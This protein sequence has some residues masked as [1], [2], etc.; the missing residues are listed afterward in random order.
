MYLTPAYIFGNAT[1]LPLL[2]VNALAQTGS[3]DSLVVKGDKVS[4]AL[5]RAT[6]YLLLNAL[7]C[8]ITR[9]LAGPYLM[10]T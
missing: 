2:L 8:N 10:R 7:V 1:S 9:F 6:V 3:L 4:S 5:R